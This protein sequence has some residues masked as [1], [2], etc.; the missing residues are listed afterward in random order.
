MGFWQLAAQWNATC[1]LVPGWS[2]WCFCPH[3][4]TWSQS[5]RTKYT[6]QISIYTI[7]FM[8]MSH[9]SFEWCS[10]YYRRNS[11]SIA[12]LQSSP[13]CKCTNLFGPAWLDSWFLLL[14]PLFFSSSWSYHQRDP[15]AGSL[16]EPVERGGRQRPH[17]RQLW[18]LPGGTAEPAGSYPSSPRFSGP[19][20]L[21]DSRF[22]RHWGIWRGKHCIGCGW[23]PC[24]TERNWWHTPKDSVTFELMMPNLLVLVLWTS[25]NKH[26]LVWYKS[27]TSS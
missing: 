10:C 25:C 7:S 5:M 24:P 21:S 14:L 23:Q 8:L 4:C 11:L 6:V 16:G 27:V 15:W 17:A 1:I 19:V 2:T 12:T 20:K 22:C 13:H 26:E 3:S 9:M 18:C